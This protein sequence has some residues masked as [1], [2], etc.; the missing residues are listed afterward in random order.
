MDPG[1][2]T[3]LTKIARPL[4]LVNVAPRLLDPV[5]SDGFDGPPT[6]DCRNEYGVTAVVVDVPVCVTAR[7]ASGVTSD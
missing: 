4:L 5:T 2:A 1:C 7:E 3:T 6:M